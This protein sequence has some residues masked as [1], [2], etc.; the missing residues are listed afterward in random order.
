MKKL[1]LSF[2]LR[3][4]LNILLWTVLIFGSIAIVFGSFIRKH[5]EEQA[6]Q[7][8][9]A[10]QNTTIQNLKDDM[11]WLEQTVELTIKRVM[12]NPSEDRH[13]SLEFIAQL[14][15]NNSLLLGVG[16]INYMD[17]S[18]HRTSL[19]YVYEDSDGLVHYN[20]VPITQYDHTKTQWYQNAT[21]KKHGEW[22]E[23][24]HDQ[25]GIHKA[26]ATYALPIRDSLQHITGVVTAD[27]ALSK[28][29][30]ELNTVQP[31]EHSYSF[32]LSK[33]GTV[34]AHP[35]TRLILKE[36]IFS[37]AKTLNDDNY[38]TIGRKIQAGEK[39]SLHCELDGIDVLVCYAPLPHIGWYV[40]SVCPY[41]AIVSEMGSVSL[42][43]LLIMV[44]G[45]VLLSICLRILLIRM[46]RPIRQMTNAAYQIAQGDFNASLPAVAV[47]DDFG[48][49]HDAFEHMQQSLKT[50]IRDLENA[51]QARE[52]I[53]GELK[54]AQR[55][56]TEILPTDFVLSQ[57][58]ESIDIDGFLKP[59]RQVGGDF[60][61]FVMK[62]GKIY[63]TIGDVSGKGIGAAIVMAM[64]CTLFRSLVSKHT[65]ASEIMSIINE[66]LARNN[67]TEMFVTMFLGILDTRTGEMAYCNAGHNA[68]YLFSVAEGCSK[69]PLLPKLPL[70]L[71]G[72]T[73]YVEQTY[74]L[75]PGQSLLLYTDGLTEAE[76]ATRQQLGAQR[77]EALLATLGGKTSHEVITDLRE[78]LK[79]FVGEAE[80]SDDLTLFTISYYGCK[81]LILDNRLAE[82]AK[83]PPFIQQLGEELALTQ[84]Q[85]MS[86]RLVLEEALMNVISYAY[87][88]RDIG[89]VNLKVLYEPQPSHL[90]FEITD[91]GKPFDPTQVKEA[92]LS[93]GVEEIPVG[94]LGIFLIRK[95]IDKVTYKRENNMNKL[96]LIKNIDK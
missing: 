90:R 25:T 36:N 66:T 41:S 62:D 37:L 39:G 75:K 10:L 91:S 61:D 8:T 11:E 53:N 46:I 60:Y 71:F 68:P 87:P 95:H 35:K 24:Y 20:C 69:L 16:Y 70:A 89:K 43:I 58:Y 80:Q 51:T 29:T 26:I 32:I 4:Y 30:E 73:S 14:V 5:E 12:A 40:V 27:V 18:V 49:L 17:Q 38:T 7:Y 47:H 15:K 9:F 79:L 94:G 33:K 76:N 48:K 19:D 44:V 67:Q 22:T 96:I 6:T 21:Q 72:N 81:T 54:A 83:L 77:V 13:K 82:L 52:R 93:L 63:F 64:T 59:A 88:K 2:Q 65:S 23:P 55:I 31:F 45:F 92:D 57:G 85:M 50:H 56:Q 28:L 86:L 3:L 84:K 1:Q 42:K 74:R 78:Q 34:V